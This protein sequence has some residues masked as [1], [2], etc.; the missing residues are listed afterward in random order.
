MEI[1]KTKIVP[2]EPRIFDKQWIEE[3]R[4]K[5]EAKKRAVRDGVIITKDSDDNENT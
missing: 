5:H 4:Q 2:N 1:D 3:I